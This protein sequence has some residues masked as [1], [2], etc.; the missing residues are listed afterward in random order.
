MKHIC[1][2][3]G[4]TTTYT[5]HGKRHNEEW[6]KYKGGYLCHKCYHKIIVNP[7]WASKWNPITSKINNPR[8]LTF[9]TKRVYLNK[10]PR[11]GTCSKCLR[12]IGEEIKQTAMHH[13]NYHYTSPLKDTIELCNSC[14][15]KE[16]VKRDKGGL[17][18]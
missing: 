13:I 14:H 9:K 12:K 11:N 17:R 5:R 8:R 2:N 6:H 4:S 18:S 3:C 10:N 1:S 7:K 16:H 15:R